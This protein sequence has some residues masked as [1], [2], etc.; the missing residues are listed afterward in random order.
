MFDKTGDQIFY[1]D[2]DKYLFSFSAICKHL[3]LDPAKTRDAIMNATHKN[4]H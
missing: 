4:Q 1:E 2:D 3:E